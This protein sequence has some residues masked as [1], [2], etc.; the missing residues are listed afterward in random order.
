[1]RRQVAET[2]RGWSPKNCS[3]RKGHLS[4]TD[5]VES[6]IELCPVMSLHLSWPVAM[7]QL[8]SF[9]AVLWPS[10]H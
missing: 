8:M 6:R 10:S 9:R 5:A 2:C 1:M 3:V 4:E 7:R